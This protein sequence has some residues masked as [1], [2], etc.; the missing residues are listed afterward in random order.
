MTGKIIAM[1]E[2]KLAKD[3]KLA[4]GRLKSLKRKKIAV[5][6]HDDSDGSC[7]AALIIRLLERL[8]GNNNISYFSTRGAPY[9]T[10]ELMDDVISE[11]PDHVVTC[12]FAGDL[13]LSAKRLE[14][15][16][17]RCIMIDHHIPK[18]YDFPESTIYLNPQIEGK[19][20]PCAAYVYDICCMISESFDEN[21]W[22]AAVGTI[23]DYG[24]SD[25][26][27]IIKACM[28]KYP[29]M[30]EKIKSI[31]NSKLFDTTFGLV[32]KIIGAAPLWASYQGA[33]LATKTLLEVDSPRDF[34]SLENDDV[35]LMFEK[36]SQIE[37]EIKKNVKR[38]QPDCKRYGP[39]MMYEISSEYP[40]KSNV[41]T[42]VSSR[43]PDNIII[44]IEKKTRYVSMSMRNQSGKFDLN[45]I[46]TECIEGLDARGGGHKK[47]AGASVSKDDIETF[48]ERFKV[49]AVEGQ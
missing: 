32:G 39:I 19:T 5:I 43:Y 8:H 16:G 1:D 2:N 12:D 14:K 48:L 23:E 45:R 28:K 26:E 24:A 25:R 13:D 4:I 44:T 41:S 33:E 10:D 20:M 9:I 46:I 11:K 30:F 6:S 49:K 21:L 31:D 27:D 38:F 36:F 15:E 3:L 37:A 22:I 35:R 34:L 18:D 29:E 7:S 47:A 17:I 40:I 42:I